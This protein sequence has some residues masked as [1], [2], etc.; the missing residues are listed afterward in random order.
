VGGDGTR[1]VGT[2][3]TLQYALPA[4]GGLPADFAAAEA[5]T[6]EYLRSYLEAQ[7]A[8][9]PSISLADLSYT[10]QESNVGTNPVSATFEVVLTFE[11][12]SGDGVALPGRA[13]VDVLFLTAFSQPSVQELITMLQGSGDASFAQTT[14]VNIVVP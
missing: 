1:V 9:N 8:F 4:G 3:F 10:V 14:G 7:F 12:N 2:P 5:T 11:D 6:I 13:D